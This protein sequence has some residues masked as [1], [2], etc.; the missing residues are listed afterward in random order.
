[1]NNKHVTDYLDYYIRLK[2]PGYAVMLTGEWGSG[3]TYFIKKVLDSWGKEVEEC[4]DS[5]VMKPIY[6]SLNGIENMG[7]VTEKIKSQIYPILH[8]KS[9][10]F[11]KELGKGLLKSSLKFDI[12][13]NA[14]DN[15][16]DGTLSYALDVF[17]IFEL[18]N[19]D[20]VRGRRILVFDDLERCK[21]NTETMFGYI[22]DF[23]EHYGCKV[24]LVAD[25]IKIGGSDDGYQVYRKVKEKL[26][27]QTFKVQNNVGTVLDGFIKEIGKDVK[28]FD[29]E[30]FKEIVVNVFQTAKYN[31]LR[32]LKQFL[33]DFNR[34][35]GF[36][37]DEYKGS[38]NYKK[39][40]EG[41][42]IYFLII[43]L[44]MKG[45]TNVELFQAVGSLSKEERIISTGYE[46]QYNVLLNKY[47]ILHS[48]HFCK[49][50]ILI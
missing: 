49:T 34:F 21:I 27:G 28:V 17:K 46:K 29:Y 50:S 16:N 11:I 37:S 20:K 22:N 41:L 2:T 47:N 48:L 45:G 24:I 25:Q 6:I 3:K 42:L 40:I 18:K 10:N 43:Y 9:A 32:V 31:N 36:V 5:V 30:P 7:R 38:D 26:I 14:A 1:M 23:V 19:T 35:E 13:F 15:K 39:F 33:F 4:G 12:D 44:E 8:S